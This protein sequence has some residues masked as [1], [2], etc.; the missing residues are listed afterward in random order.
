[1][2]IIIVD[3]GS[4]RDRSNR[5]L[6]EL[7]RLFAQRFAHLY[8]VVEPA[9]ME[10]AEPS[11]ATA[12]DRC[13][14][15]GAG[16]MIVAPYFLGPR[17]HGSQDI[18]NLASEAAANHPGTTFHIAETLGIDDLMLELL[19]KRVQECTQARAVSAATS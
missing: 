11:I 18:P 1:T 10:L 19:N 13:V 14:R 15:R 8:E 6:E 3:H 2:G 9:H 4:R 5:L 17:R 16:R 7:A 12:H